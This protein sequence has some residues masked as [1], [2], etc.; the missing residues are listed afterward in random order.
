MAA[1]IVKTLGPADKSF[2]T[3]AD[4][5]A[6]MDV[7]LSRAYKMIRQMRAELIQEGC[8]T[9]AYPAGKIPKRYFNQKCMID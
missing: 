8:L 1:G 5:Q 7:S 6:L 9:A 3:A 4:V 2:Y